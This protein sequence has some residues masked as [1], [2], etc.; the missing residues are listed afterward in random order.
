VATAY[1]D[2]VALN[3]GAGAEY[4]DSTSFSRRALAARPKAIEHYRIALR[5][6]ADPTL[7]RSAFVNLTRLLVGARLNATFFCVND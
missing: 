7:R 1:K 2:I 3:R 5:S 4:A 6:L